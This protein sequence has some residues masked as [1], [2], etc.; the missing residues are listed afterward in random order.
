MILVTGASGFVGHRLC[1][2]LAQQGHALRAA[3]RNR[4]HGL[5]LFAEVVAVGE[6]D[7]QT[8]WSGA[9][10]D[11]DV[12]IHLAARV[13]V[14]KETATDPLAEFRAVNVLGTQR[15]ARA[16]TESGVRR[17]VYV[18]SLKVNGETTEGS[19]FTECDHPRPQDPYGISKWEAEQSLWRIA[20]ETG[21]EVVVVRPPLVYGPNVG[22]SFLRL[23][24]LVRSGLPLPFGA[25]ENQRSMIYNAN[26]VDA[27]ILCATREEAAGKT[28]LVSDG[29]D[30]STACLVTQLARL[31]HKPA[32]LVPIPKILLQIV[33]RC[34]GKAD[35]VGRLVGSL[36]VD[37]SAIRSD[38]AWQPPFSTAEGLDETVQWFQ[39]T[40]A[41]KARYLRRQH[42]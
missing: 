27:L 25:I 19:S 26:L 21:L 33:G 24:K 40:A 8:H 3:V 35:E 36:R 6:V 11:V 30:W 32:R 2:E 5:S 41:G 10:T 16:A 17:L 9:L 14:M 39:G 15:L 18:S 42:E 28:Y 31:M 22:G 13:H 20:H 1:S 12:I 29:D 7:A 34:T 23:L 4:S 37:T 38:L